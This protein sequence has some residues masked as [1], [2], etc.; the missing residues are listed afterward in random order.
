MVRLW[1]T[2][3][4]YSG[5]FLR[6]FDGVAWIFQEQK[7]YRELFHECMERTADLLW[8]GDKYKLLYDLSQFAASVDPFSEWEVFTM[9]SLV[10]L[11]R[12]D[13]AERFF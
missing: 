11:G 9:E 12:Y 13:D 4:L 7:K 10:A 5:H 6:G 2:C 3:H 1:D 8:E